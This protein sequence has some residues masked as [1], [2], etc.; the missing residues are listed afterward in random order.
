M[1]PPPGRAVRPR[2]AAPRSPRPR[3]APASPRPPPSRLPTRAA[4]RGP[5]PPRAARL[6]RTPPALARLARIPLPPRA[7]RLARTPRRA[8]RP[9]TT[10][11]CCAAQCGTSALPTCRRWPARTRGTE[12]T[13][14][15]PVPTVCRC[16]APGSASSPSARSG[17]GSR[18]GWDRA[19]PA[20]A[21][22]PAPMTPGAHPL[23]APPVR[24]RRQD[25]WNVV[26]GSALV[27]RLHPAPAGGHGDLQRH[28][29]RIDAGHLAA[30]QLGEALAFAADDLEDQ[31]VVDLQDHAGG[32]ALGGHG[33][34]NGDHGLLD[35]V[36]G[37]T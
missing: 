20:S 22:N 4:R 16:S 7:A 32:E 14:R 31:L 26:A 33:A 25:F 23:G 21:T 15:S 11:S 29:Q 34:V 35:D 27:L 8:A 10:P 36:G 9:A 1:A 2:R 13:C 6:A 37:R 3:P 18:G 24:F 30:D 5:T 17:C 28:A 12:G 19:V